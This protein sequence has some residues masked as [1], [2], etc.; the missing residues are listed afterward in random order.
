M[1]GT[2]GP[3]PVP[4][5]QNDRDLTQEILDRLNSDDASLESSNDFPDVDQPVMKAALD[6][7]SSRS[8]ITYDTHD[9]EVIQLTSEAQKIKE[10][11]S[12][13]Y[14]VWDAVRQRDRLPLAELKVGQLSGHI[15]PHKY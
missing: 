3:V 12:H 1:V 8:M 4:L 10:H 7:L 5:H 11:G 14:K 2:R 15:R 6:R 9:N 13:E